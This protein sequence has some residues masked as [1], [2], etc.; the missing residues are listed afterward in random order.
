MTS[1]ATEP[2]SAARERVEQEQARTQVEERAFQRFHTHVA[3]I[4]CSRSQNEAWGQPQNSISVHLNTEPGGAMVERIE[5]AFQETLLDTTHYDDEYN[6]ASIYET[7]AAEFGP[8]IAHVLRQNTYIS[9]DLQ[10]TILDAAKQASRERKAFSMWLDREATSLAETAEQLCEIDAAVSELANSPLEGWSARELR[11]ARDRLYTLEHDCDM[12]A[13]QRQ[14]FLNERPPMDNLHL[15][16]K[17]FDEYL[18]HSQDF[19]YPVLSAITAHVERIQRVRGRICKH[20]A[21]E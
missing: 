18:Y 11:A 16:G 17:E 5:N 20:L 21:T 14:A 10:T 15:D 2:I 13:N 9:S 12:L 1:Q 3:N 8:A 6:D 4:E 19:T 7:M